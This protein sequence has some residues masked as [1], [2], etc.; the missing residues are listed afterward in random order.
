MRFLKITC[1]SLLIMGFFGCDN[2]PTDPQ[3]MDSFDRKAMLANWADNIIIPAY[4][5]FATKTESLKNAGTAFNEETSQEN[6]DLLRNAFK[7]AYRSWQKVSMFAIGKA[8]EETVRE[9]FNI[10]PVDVED[11]KE[12][13]SSTSYNLSLPSEFDQ[14]GFPALDYLLFG[15]G[16][17]N[18][19]FIQAFTDPSLG[20]NRRNYLL[21]LVNRI[22]ELTDMVLTDWQ[23]GFRDEFVNNSANS[24][25]ASVDRL[26]N[27]YIFYYEKHLRA[28]KVGIPAGV[29]SGSPEAGLVEALY[30]EDFNRELLLIAL[31][32]VQDFFNG[33]HYDGSQD[34]VGLDDYLDELETTKN[35]EN[36]S[37]LIND[38]FDAARTAIEGLNMNLNQQ[39][40]D[41]NI[42]MLSAY[43]QLQLNVV[44]LKVD[45]LQALNINVDFV[46]ADGD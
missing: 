33:K 36:L 2:G 23:S 5:D 46:D 20:E 7:D 14:Q 44:L 15:L 31:D 19:D 3:N 21:D 27:D 25:T 41:D 10:F 18:D 26:V 9:Y 39:V 11:L 1:L 42:S 8:E 38:Q 28:G 45:M 22:D 43:D 30:A 16:E 4:S 29:F 32:A 37:K 34:A 12:N 17:N 35:E 40:V 24:A 13:I 6:L